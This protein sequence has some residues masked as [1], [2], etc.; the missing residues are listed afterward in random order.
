MPPLE[1]LQRV[2]LYHLDALERQG[3]FTTGLL[4]EVSETP[5]RRQY[6]ADQ[7]NAEIT[8]VNDWRDEALLLN[9]ANF[10]L[11]EQALFTQAGILGLS[12]L[13]ALDLDEFRARLHRGARIVGMAAPDDLI[14]EGWWEQAHTLREE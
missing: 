7:I 6:L 1:H 3:I 5:T 14:V 13:L 2:P 11:D 12:D 9:L 8:D 10:G 4:L